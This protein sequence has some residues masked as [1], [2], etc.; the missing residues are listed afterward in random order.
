MESREWFFE[1]AHTDS[2]LPANDDMFTLPANISASS[3][4][5][6]PPFS[7]VPLNFDGLQPFP[8]VNDPVLQPPQQAKTEDDVSDVTDVQLTTSPST[9]CLDPTSNSP[10]VLLTSV[11]RQDF[12]VF[13]NYIKP[14]KE[15]AKRPNHRSFMPALS[16]GRKRPVSNSSSAASQDFPRAEKSTSQKRPADD[17]S[18]QRH[19]EMMRQNRG[20]FNKKFKELTE[21]L[22]AL[23]T[24]AVEDKPMKNKIQIL[25][26]AMYQYA[27]MESQRAAFK[28]ELLFSP[29]IHS[30]PHHHVETMAGAPTLQDACQIIVRNMCASQDWK[31]GEVWTRNCSDTISESDLNMFTLSSAFVSPKNMPTTRRALNEFAKKGK[32]D[33]MDPFLIRLA[34]FKHAIWISDISTK[35]H[36]SKRAQEAVAAG[37]TT[38]LMIPI[39]VNSPLS[40]RP[41]AIVVLMHADD[42]LF[43]F[44]GRVRTFHSE[45][46]CRLTTLTSAVIESRS[47]C[48]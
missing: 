15:I 34:R 19:N 47:N 41:D 25:D 24:S 26:R 9:K 37:V 36:G 1:T 14:R 18:R 31:Y 30:T 6:Q 42:D 28:N 21:L 13:E 10:A 3:I 12:S 46:V 40:C 4:W 20:R 27:L 32:K 39:V 7:D 16:L 44:P 17:S 43:S 5:N 8:T 33:N 35:Q 22:D 38:V 2:H 23:K 48:P 45:S 11:D 29:P